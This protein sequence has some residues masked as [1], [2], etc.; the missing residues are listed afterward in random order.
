MKKKAAL[1]V[2][3]L[4]GLVFAASPAPAP[5]S[6]PALFKD[7]RQTL[8]IARAQGRKEVSILLA[9]KPGAAASVAKEA[10]KLGG[11]VRYRDD[12]IGYL[13]VKAPI[14]QATRL[15]EFAG[16]QAASLDY[17]DDYPNRLGPGRDVLPLPAPPEGPSAPPWPPAL[18]DYP[19]AHPYSPIKDLAAADFLA[20][21]PTWDGRGVVI[22]VLDGNLDMLLREVTKV[23]VLIA[24]NPLDC[25]VLGSG[26]V[27]DELNLLRRVAVTS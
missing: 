21:H 8:A 20:Q 27:L 11:D 24:E 22:G 10:A 5:R 12:E 2:G 17:D 23:P 7:S 1:V 13:R 14:D 26:K 19:L 25:V 3:S 15:A 9:A 4:A 6:R 16:V 18:S